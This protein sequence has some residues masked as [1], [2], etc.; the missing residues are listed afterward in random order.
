M[1]GPH[2]LD[3]VGGGLEIELGHKAGGPE[4]PQ[5]VVGEGHL[6]IERGAQT[7]GGQVDEPYLTYCPRPDFV[8]PAWF[9][10][11]N[12]AESFYMGIPGLSWVNVVIGDPLM[13]LQ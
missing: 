6:G 13:R 8:L 4:H 1:T 9:Q 7:V 5:R 10:G 12:L 2:R 3:Q 11:R